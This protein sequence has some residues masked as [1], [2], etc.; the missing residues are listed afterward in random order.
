LFLLTFAR[1]QELAPAVPSEV[2][3]LNLHLEVHDLPHLTTQDG[4][5]AADV[6]LQIVLAAQN[7]HCNDHSESETVVRTVTDASLQEFTTKLAGTNCVTD[8]GP[9]KLDATFMP[10]SSVQADDLIAALKGNRAFLVQYKGSFM[11]LYGATYDA[12]L[13]SDGSRMNVVRRL[14][15]LDPR[16]QDDRRWVSFRR[17][18]DHLSDIAGFVSIQPQGM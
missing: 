5:S 17:D 16:Y 8:T 11:V 7:I 3:H 14:L 10:T 1:A 18:N 15:L 6:S 13:R 2:I 12:H 4:T 9:R